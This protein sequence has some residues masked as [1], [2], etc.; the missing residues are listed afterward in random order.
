MS[1]WLAFGL[2]SLVGSAGVCAAVWLLLRVASGTPEAS[3]AS[4]AACLRGFSRRLESLHVI[5][6]LEGEKVLLPFEQIVVAIE[7]AELACRR[8]D[9][10]LPRSSDLN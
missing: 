4:L 9:A 5:V 8:C 7:N 3:L 6:S 10:P 2:G 1:A